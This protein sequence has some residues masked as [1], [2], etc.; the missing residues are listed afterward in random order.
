[1]RTH[2]AQRGKEGGTMSDKSHTNATKIN[3]RSGVQLI[4]ILT[5]VV[6]CTLFGIPCRKKY[7]YILINKNVIFK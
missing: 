7:T 3:L 6:V 5:F 2:G 1:M 4:F